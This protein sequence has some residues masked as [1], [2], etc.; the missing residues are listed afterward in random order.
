MELEGIRNN[1]VGL[2]EKELQEVIKEVVALSIRNMHL[3]LNL[4]SEK[5]FPRFKRARDLP[6]KVLPVG[7]DSMVRERQ[8]HPPLLKPK[9]APPPPVKPR[10]IP[11][12][13]LKDCSYLQ[14]D[15]AFDNYMSYSSSATN[16]NRLTPNASAVLTASEEQLIARNV[17]QYENSH[18]SLEEPGE[19]VDYQPSLSVTSNP[20]IPWD[21]GYVPAGFLEQVTAVAMAKVEAKSLAEPKSDQAYVMLGSPESSQV[22]VDE[23]V[24]IPALAYIPYD[25]E[26]DEDEDVDDYLERSPAK[27]IT[28][29]KR[30]R[31]L[32]KT[33]DVF[34][35][36]GSDKTSISSKVT[37]VFSSKP[38]LSS[39][40]RG[41]EALSQASTALGA[42]GLPH[43][44]KSN[45]V[46]PACPT[47]IWVGVVSK[48][49]CDPYT[50]SFSELVHSKAV[51]SVYARY[52]L[53]RLN[54]REFK[55]Y[56]INP[57]MR[58]FLR[59]QLADENNQFASVPDIPFAIH[60]S[61]PLEITNRSRSSSVPMIIHLSSSFPH[62]DLPSRFGSSSVSSA[63]SADQMQSN[64]NPRS[65]SFHDHYLQDEVPFKSQSLPSSRC[66][67]PVLR[68]NLNSTSGFA[69]EFITS[70]EESIG[71]SKNCNECCSQP[72]AEKPVKLNDKPTSVEVNTE[73]LTLNNQ[74]DD[75]SDQPS[76]IPSNPPFA[77]LPHKK[78]YSNT[79]EDFSEPSHKGQ[80]FFC[81][82][83]L[84]KNIS[85]HPHNIT[86]KIIE[87]T[88]TNDA[89]KGANQCLSS[90]NEY[91]SGL[92]LESAA[93]PAASNEL[94]QYT[95]YCTTL[96]TNISDEFS[97]RIPSKSENKP[98]VCDRA[99]DVPMSQEKVLGDVH[100]RQ[101]KYVSQVALQLENRV[102]LVSPQNKN[103]VDEVTLENEAHEVALQPKD[104]AVEV[105]SQS[106]NRIEV[107][108][109]PNNRVDE[110]TPQLKYRAL[111]IAP[112]PE[113][114]MDKIVLL[115]ENL[116][117]EVALQVD[118]DVNQVTLKPENFLDEIVLHLV[119]DVDEI[120][121]QPLNDIDEISQQPL[122]DID[123]ISQQPL[124]DID[125]I[126][127]QPLNDI[128]EISLQPL[129]D[130]DETSLQPLNDVDE[131]SLQPLNDVN[132]ISLQPLNDV[133]EI[134]L[135]LLKDVNEISLQPLN[136]VD[137]TSLQ[138]LNDVD[139]ISLQL[140][141]DVKET[142]LQ[143]LN[144]VDEIS[145]QPLNDVD[146]ISL[147]LLKDAKETSLQPLNDVDEISLKPLNDVDEISLQ[148]LNDV[149][150][151]SLQPLNDVDEISLQPL[152][153]VDEIASRSDSSSSYNSSIADLLNDAESCPAAFPNRDNLIGPYKFENESLPPSPPIRSSSLKGVLNFDPKLQV[154]SSA[155]HFRSFTPSMSLPITPDWFSSSS[156]VST[157]SL[158]LING[159]NS[160][161]PFFVLNP[162]ASVNIE[163]PGLNNMTSNSQGESSKIDHNPFTNETQ[164]DHDY[165]LLDPVEE[166]TM[167]IPVD[168][169]SYKCSSEPV[170]LVK[171]SRA[172]KQ[173]FASNCV[174]SSS[175]SELYDNDGSD[176]SN[177]SIES[178][179]RTVSEQCYQI[180]KYQCDLAANTC[181][182]SEI[183][184]SEHPTGP[185][186]N[187]KSSFENLPESV[188]ELE[189]ITENDQSTLGD[190]FEPNK[191]YKKYEMHE[192]SIFSPISSS[193]EDFSS[194]LTTIID[195]LCL[196]N[197]LQINQ[198]TARHCSM[199]HEGVS[200]THDA[201]I[202]LKEPDICHSSTDTLLQ[203]KGDSLLDLADELL[204]QNDVA[205]EN[206]DFI[207]MEHPVHNHPAVIDNFSLTGSLDNLANDL[208]FKQNYS[209][210]ANYL[211]K[212]SAETNNSGGS[213][214]NL[215]NDLISFEEIHNVS[216]G[217]HEKEII[218]GT[219][220]EGFDS[221]QPNHSVN[222]GQRNYLTTNT[223]PVDSESLEDFSVNLVES[224]VIWL[225]EPVRQPNELL[226]VL[227][228]EEDCKEVFNVD[229]VAVH[230]TESNDVY[231]IYNGEYQTI[232]DVESKTEEDL[233]HCEPVRKSPVEQQNTLNVDDVTGSNV[234]SEINFGGASGYSSDVESLKHFKVE[235]VENSVTKSNVPVMNEK[236]LQASG[237]ILFNQNENITR[238]LG[239]KISL[240]NNIP[241]KK[242][243]GTSKRKLV[244]ASISMDSYSVKRKIQKWS[245][246]TVKSVLKKSCVNSIFSTSC[247]NPYG[248]S[249]LS[250][251][252]E[253]INSSSSYGLKTVQGIHTNIF[254]YCSD[255]S[256]RRLRSSEFSISL[257]NS[258]AVALET[259]DI[260][261]GFFFNN[262]EQVKKFSEIV[263]GKE[264]DTENSVKASDSLTARDAFTNTA[265]N[266]SS[267][268]PTTQFKFQPTVDCKSKPDDDG[269]AGSI[270]NDDDP[271]L[272]NAS[273]SSA[274][275]RLGPA[276]IVDNSTRCQ[277]RAVKNKS[278]V[279]NYSI[280]NPDLHEQE[281]ISAQRILSPCDNQCDDKHELDMSIQ[282]NLSQGN[283]L[284]MCDSNCYS[285]NQTKEV[286][287]DNRINSKSKETAVKPEL[288]SRDI[289]S[290]DSFT[291]KTNT[292]GSGLPT[293]CSFT[294]KRHVEQWVDSTAAWG[295]VI[296][297]KS[298]ELIPAPSAETSLTCAANP[299]TSRQSLKRSFDELDSSSVCSTTSV[300]TANDWGMV[301]PHQWTTHCWA[302]LWKHLHDLPLQ[303]I[304]ILEKS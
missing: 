213:L 259:L 111:E 235:L 234:P 122:N 245:P 240:Q 25:S 194:D 129:K 82:Q 68:T 150:E 67:S 178:F 55:S 114:T 4:T 304:V 126:S 292:Q 27:R 137:E 29:V 144:D 89:L 253:M 127:Q 246:P 112:P 81:N 241:R 151:I 166:S 156:D 84:L 13:S 47:T 173:N 200:N 57:Q 51:G 90:S 149:D 93:T 218:V 177:L 192:N 249:Y 167:L 179:Q 244:D 210:V 146:E 247:L 115:P 7:Y 125:E 134:S 280:S 302:L 17:D 19:H 221:D 118:K 184:I 133:D 109:Q 56:S 287:C 9:T 153:D 2:G 225:D 97:V 72:R 161:D 16:N 226:N 191:L 197:P 48:L 274:T 83:A 223:D 124:N 98:Y 248:D 155:D 69:T 282:E 206:G 186:L 62:T 273:A 120:S 108:V 216:S 250:S 39:H 212:Q 119:E 70:S 63:A 35:P 185:A 162:F 278:L 258:E 230:D 297:S 217:F 130:V 46:S 23:P 36:N 283:L 77:V 121:Q 190:L 182:E 228:L 88:T 195:P 40:S 296:P 201:T 276:E 147:Q 303:R 142:S 279:K 94:P 207:Y 110:M 290:N 255:S 103:K 268:I 136:N 233:L 123:E 165:F 275:N 231:D 299:L 3:D 42:M 159:V 131:I 66:S 172:I 227:P 211:P 100:P 148:P 65:V 300:S 171:S 104:R 71:S 44:P 73:N 260:T 224:P 203:S 20:N 175:A 295:S 205:N 32:H 145:L 174:R 85:I 158:N 189:R 5:S 236:S 12:V 169:C 50:P 21:R 294:L 64:N 143:A 209:S 92:H 254:E 264:H 183:P 199:A 293:I 164:Y 196:D 91:Q 45:F 154:F 30:D 242:I 18:E 6:D 289:A 222:I 239:K 10:E 49:P 265:P 11:S 237:D 193:L 202:V 188:E 15:F 59:S 198:V 141:K 102:N 14:E 117:D 106:K 80:G 107:A 41:I 116:V 132:K 138:P 96:I 135:Q 76:V 33:D 257:E 220:G 204:H 269:G 243:K 284:K 163:L 140:L 181:S 79:D 60:S 285:E 214:E 128:D 298:T 267:P 288:D 301:R 251:S 286:Q 99:S 170:E 8:T 105:A 277:F 152:N 180:S 52:C 232:D 31:I 37:E 26:Y 262:Y 139:E 219:I 78:L 74:S 160:E 95:S 215:A 53:N 34:I 58:K 87:K 266:A 38:L 168:L 261:S 263:P 43:H 187:Y 61:V 270:D 271:P 252:N 28:S 238:S 1:E 256:P 281:M 291:A 208:I 75:D 101:E 22:T 176:S 229:S 86:A 113:K 157:A 24:A 54:S 272:H